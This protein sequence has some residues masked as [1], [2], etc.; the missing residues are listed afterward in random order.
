[1]QLFEIDEDEEICQDYRLIDSNSTDS[2]DN[3]SVGDKAPCVLSPLNLN[4][5]CTETEENP[6]NQII[7]LGFV[8]ALCAIECQ[9]KPC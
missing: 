5:E 3:E 7:D 6:E 1:M 9:K 4:L 2:T 8:N